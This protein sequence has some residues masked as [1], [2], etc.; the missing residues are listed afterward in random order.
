[1]PQPPLGP[2]PVPSDQGAWEGLLPIPLATHNEWASPAQKALWFGLL[3]L[4]SHIRFQIHCMKTHWP[5]DAKLARSAA[6]DYD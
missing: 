5:Q 6:L 1:M 4:V 2:H 3:N